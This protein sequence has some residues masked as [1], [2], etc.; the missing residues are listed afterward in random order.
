MVLVKEFSKPHVN[1]SKDATS[2][3]TNPIFFKR[4]RMTATL[5][6]SSD[7]GLCGG[8]SGTVGWRQAVIP[9]IP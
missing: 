6:G 8:R 5:G 7:S 4:L 3:Q 2:A 9:N 1:M